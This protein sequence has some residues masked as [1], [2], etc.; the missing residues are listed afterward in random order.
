MS[1]KGVQL[2]DPVGAAIN[3]SI[4]HVTQTLINIWF[5]RNP[6]DNEL[7]AEDLKSIFTDLCNKKISNFK[8]ARVLLAS[9]VIALY[10]VDRQWTEQHLLPLF[11]WSNPVEAK[12]VWEG[13]LWS[14]RL[15]QPLLRALKSQFL[16]SANHYD[17]LG[18]HRRQFVTFLTYAAL[19]PTEEF[20]V[21]EFRS[22]V[23]ALP[24]EGLEESAQAL[25]QALEGAADQRE[26]YWK[27]RTQPFW[28]KIWPKSLELA[29]P[30]IA[31]S[32]TR[33][34]I[35]ARGEFP[36]AL[37]AVIDWL[38]PIEHPDHVVHL[39]HESGLC[40]KYSAEALKLLCAVIG[41]Q[42][43]G[44][45]KLGQC[46]NQIVQTEPRLEQEPCFLKLR[47]YDRKPRT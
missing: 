22:A 41:D 9:N 45:R 31:V 2:V 19:G 39:L 17:D 6:N 12:A 24:L 29:T 1:N 40:S 32:L 34:A 14:P 43:W 38:K 30:R 20:S 11:D 37:A 33:L 16:D 7:I 8:H 35:A 28:Q 46:L 26:D 3:H 47:E 42:P 15:Y 18:K 5:K 13:F 44:P 23:C 27:N 36:A 4:G 21:E 10:R 25:Y